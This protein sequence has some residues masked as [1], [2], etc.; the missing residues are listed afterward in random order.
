MPAHHKATD[1]KVGIVGSIDF[2]AAGLVEAYVAGLSVTATV[3]SGGAKGVDS[4]GEA[5]ARERGLKV[6]VFHAD[7]QA[8]GRKAGP[9]RNRQIVMASDRIVAFWNG[10]SRGTLNTLVQAHEAGLPIEI[11]GPSGEAIPL[12]MAL[13]VAEEKG[14]VRGIR[15][16]AKRASKE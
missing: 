3:V 13:T 2:P 15:L 7:W 10:H 6:Q 8:L 14:V 5:A 4:W 16:A 9:I 12:E 1:E 11:Y